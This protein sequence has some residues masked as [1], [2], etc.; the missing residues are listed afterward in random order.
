MSH[1]TAR[2]SAVHRKPAVLHYFRYSVAAAGIS[3]L[4]FAHCHH[5]AERSCRSP[6]GIGGKPRLWL[7]F[8]DHT[9]VR[10]GRAT[11]HASAGCVFSAS[12][13]AFERD[14]DYD[15]ASSGV[16]SGFRGGVHCVP[17]TLLWA[18][19]KNSLE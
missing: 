2:A 9:A 7:A 8:G 13:G 4:L 14:S 19:T 1:L 5:G 10:P 12:E 16:A 3:P 17:K 11:V 15:Q 18:E 6:G